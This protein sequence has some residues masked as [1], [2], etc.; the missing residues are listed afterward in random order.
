MAKVRVWLGFILVAV[1]LVALP[2]GAGA[3]VSD[4]PLT[5]SEHTAEVLRDRGM[6]TRYVEM[7]EDFT[8]EHPYS[9]IFR[10]T[11]TNVFIC[12]INGLPSVDAS[13]AVIIPEW[14]ST[15]SGY[16]SKTNVFRAEVIGCRST[17]WVKSDQ[18]DGRK[19]GEFVTYEPQLFLSGV[20]ILPTGPV[21]L[22]VDPVNPN[23]VNNV[24]EWDYGVAKRRLR[25]IEGSVLGSWVFPRNPGGEVRIKYNQTGDFRLKLGLYAVNDD[26]EVISTDVLDRA[27]YPLKVSDTSTFYPDDDPEV[28]SVDGW[29]GHKADPGIDWGD[30]RE[31][32]GT[33]AD[34]VGVDYQGTIRISSDTTSGKWKWL[35][36]NVLV[37]DTSS[38]P[39]GA[40]IESATLSI[41][42]YDK[43]DELNISPTV[44]IYASDPASDTALEAAD[45]KNAF[46]INYDTPFSNFI[47][48]SSWSTSGYNDFS[49]NN[50]GLNNISVTGVSKFGVREATYDVGSSTPSWSGSATTWMLFYCAEQGTGYEPKL[51]VTYTETT[52]SVTTNTVTS[53]GD[54][55]ATLSA[56]ITSTGGDASADFIGFVWDTVSRADPGNTSPDSS[57][58]SN[59]YTESGSFGVGEFTHQVTGLSEGTT[60]Y[61]R[62]AAHNSEGWAYGNEVSF[63]TWTLVLWFEPAVMIAGDVLPDRQGDNDGTINWGANPSNIEV[64]VGALQSEVSTVSTVTTTEEAPN[65]LDPIDVG[66]I[67]P[68]MPE[69]AALT[70]MP[71]YDSV[72]KAAESL[73]TSTAVMYLI[74][75]WVGSMVLGVAG[76]VALGSGWGFIGGYTVGGALAMGTPVP[77]QFLIITPA[78]VVI[79]GTFLWKRY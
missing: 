64:T 28:T 42:G 25:I 74:F 53:I 49:L 29:V 57:D 43:K 39:D 40:T 27:E 18:P 11:R 71:L 72:A 48:Y 34:D 67:M 13:G 6:D 31:A 30:L 32:A 75:M 60:Y 55:T 21:L 65:L 17:Y 3:F 15:G 46:T 36:R 7:V 69:D 24:L 9:R 20:E 51:V 70:A 79:L 8:A 16:E 54:T 37:F 12:E 33:N 45:F 1:G 23:Y 68:E 19:R 77:F 14:E 66:E 50:D 63:G 22:P 38:I 44:N 73:G 62:G 56:N 2:T 61:A 5:I 4:R 59:Y 10:D 76:L 58:Y 52:P 35:T 78:F 47:S 41:Y 26:E